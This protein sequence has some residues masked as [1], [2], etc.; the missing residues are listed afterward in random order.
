MGD[1]AFLPSPINVRI[2]DRVT[3]KNT[4]IETHTVTSD[5]FDSGLLDPGLTFE[6]RFE[7]VGHFRYSCMI[8]PS[9]TGEVIVS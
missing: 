4:D 1:K 5:E 7:K 6:H 9:M 3:W 2:G 8:H